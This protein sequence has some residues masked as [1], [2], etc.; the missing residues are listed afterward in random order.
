MSECD[1][2][3]AQI[4]VRWEETVR[5]STVGTVTVP[6]TCHE[7]GSGVVLTYNLHSLDEEVGA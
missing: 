6:G 2:P 4:T 7:C 3:S 5:E 1:H